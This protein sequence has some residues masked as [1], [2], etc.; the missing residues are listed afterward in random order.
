MKKST[1]KVVG[2]LLSCL[3]SIII[4]NTIID[5]LNDISTDNIGSEM[6]ILKNND[7]ETVLGSPKKK[8]TTIFK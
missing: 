8:C 5:T 2:I 1:G 4:P 6:Q 3:L 7:V